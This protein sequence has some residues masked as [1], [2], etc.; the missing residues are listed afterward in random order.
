[1][2][3]AHK[4]SSSRPRSGEKE[5]TFPP[6]YQGIKGAT[7][8]IL[9]AHNKEGAID[10]IKYETVIQALR[11]YERDFLIQIWSKLGILNEVRGILNI[12]FETKKD[13]YVAV[14]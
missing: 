14:E 7:L 12:I 4:L 2:R 9:N 3:N 6:L 11:S 5:S 10:A 1:M 8:Y 13:V